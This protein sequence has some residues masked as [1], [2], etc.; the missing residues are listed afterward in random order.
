MTQEGWEA[1]RMV[2]SHKADVVKG[3]LGQI[4]WFFFS[5][6]STIAAKSQH[7]FGLSVRRCP[8][9]M[10]LGGGANRGYAASG[11]S[12]VFGSIPGSVTLPTT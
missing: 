4:L 2:T 11:R 1:A 3:P 7:T 5:T 6:P 10:D 8:P 9:F 12:S